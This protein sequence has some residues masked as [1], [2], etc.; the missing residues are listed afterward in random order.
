MVSRGWPRGVRGRKMTV[1]ALLFTGDDSILGALNPETSVLNLWKQH[2]GKV[3]DYVWSLGLSDFLYLHDNRLRGLPASIANLKRLRYLN[4]SENRFEA[5]PAAVC[6]LSGLIEL[7]MTDTA[8]EALP[9]AIGRLTNLRELHLRNNRLVMVPEAIGGPSDQR[10]LR[11]GICS[12]SASRTT[13]RSSRSGPRRRATVSMLTGGRR[14]RWASTVLRS[15]K[16][17]GL[18]AVREHRRDGESVFSRGDVER[19]IHRHTSAPGAR[20]CVGEPQPLAR[21]YV[22]VIRASVVIHSDVNLAVPDIRV[23]G[24]LPPF[25]REEAVAQ[26]VLDQRLQQEARYERSLRV[27]ARLDDESP[28]VLRSGCFRLPRRRP[29]NPT[30]R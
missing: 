30:P 28:R 8:I 29:G 17:G 7:R 10:F 13:V 3:P 27:A 18:L 22:A 19:K 24:Y 21:G 11:V 14:M 15:I 9:E 26:C 12:G 23:Y 25:F 1:P 5:V 16:R 2:L 20:A 4:L 6:E